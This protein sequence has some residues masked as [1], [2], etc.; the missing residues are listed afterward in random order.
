MAKVLH[1][2]KTEKENEL[3]VILD[4]TIFHPQGGGQPADE[5]F[6]RSQDGAINFKVSAL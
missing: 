2:E 3:A 5:G 6:I 1:F 4:R